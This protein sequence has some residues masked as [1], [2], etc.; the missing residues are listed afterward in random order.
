MSYD[1][2]NNLFYVYRKEGMYDKYCGSIYI[3]EPT[4]CVHLVRDNK[5]YIYF[6][7]K[8]FCCMCCTSDQGCG[9]IKT[10][11][12]KNYG[13]YYTTTVID[14]NKVNEF[15]I[16]DT[17]KIIY[18][19]Y[20]IPET[21]QKSIPIRINYENISD[22]HIIKNSYKEGIK[23]SEIFNLPKNMKNCEKSCGYI[24]NCPI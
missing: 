18:D 8:N 13:T 17:S 1:K 15:L 12:V 6:P 3:K 14:G 23:N 10:D 21:P 20:V 9:I 7:D 19:E 4:S 24:S 22:M 5:R 11:W 2:T 16:L